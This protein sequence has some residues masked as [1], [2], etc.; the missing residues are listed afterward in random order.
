MLCQPNSGVFR[1]TDPPHQQSSPSLLVNQSD[2][3]DQSGLVDQGGRVGQ[4]ALEGL[5]SRDDLL[6]SC[7]DF[8]FATVP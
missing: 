1:P 2:L 6:Y 3:L 8:W 7:N 4:S 5:G